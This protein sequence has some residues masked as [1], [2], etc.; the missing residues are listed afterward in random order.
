MRGLTRRRRVHPTARLVLDDSEAFNPRSRSRRSGIT[1]RTVVGLP[2]S[3]APPAT[4]RRRFAPKPTR[5]RAVDRTDSHEPAGTVRSGRGGCVTSSAASYAVV[6][7]A[8]AEITVRTTPPTTVTARRPRPFEP[9]NLGPFHQTF[10][11][12]ITT[13][14]GKRQSEIVAAIGEELEKYDGEETQYALAY[15]LTLSVLSDYVAFGNYPVVSSGRAYLVNVL[16]VDGLTDARRRAITKGLFCS[17]RDRSLAERGQTKWLKATKAAL[18]VAPL[19]TAAVVA[20]LVAGPPRLRLV[21]ARTNDRVLDER[22]M[23]RA[24]R[25]TWSM[26]AE[27]SAPGREVAYI[28]VDERNPSV[29]LGILQFRN[30]V[31]EIVARDR[32]LGIVAA[33]DPNTGPAGYLRFLRDG[34]ARDRVRASGDV[35]SQLFSH[36]DV[37]DLKVQPGEDR[38]VARLTEVAAAERR[39]YKEARLAGDD[40]AAGH[41][42]KSKRAETASEVLRGVNA[43]RVAAE[44]PEPIAALAADTALL[45]DLNAGLKKIW[46]YHMG[47]VALEMSVCGAAPPFGPMRLGKLLA[48]VAGSREV[49]DAWGT[50]R[51]LGSIAATTYLPTVRDAIPNPGPLFVTTSGVYPGHSAQYNRIRVGDR[52]WRK[53]GDSLGF[54]SFQVSVATSQLAGAY[55]ASVDGYRHVTRTFGEG[56]SAKFR[57]VGRALARLNIPD[58]LRHEISRPLY[59]L[60]LVD[61]PQGA[62]LGWSSPT[63][64]VEP[65]LDEIAAAWWT[66][67]VA[68]HAVR[69]GE[70]ASASQDLTS[71]IA[72]IA[73]ATEALSG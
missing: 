17:A 32:W 8:T 28:A 10:I 2:G 38:A 65:T 27:S 42:A 73:R 66:R 21:E 59:A 62:L 6:V 54:G 69:L 39:L 60:P 44:A 12:F 26:G 43:F 30:V 3:P 70:A 15:R 64:R 20:D 50:D 52:P 33:F 46:H 7:P 67:W 1:L 68:P 4:R 51:P 25:A 40:R 22:G 53:I 72:S 71:T 57:E 55:T 5:P 36:I 34:D 16:E 24:V 9:K 31:P 37:H 56:A 29:P 23:W 14:S 47:F 35:L 63:R 49:A 45:K 18:E 11:S 19:P 48:A 13:M 61:D 58:L 41:L